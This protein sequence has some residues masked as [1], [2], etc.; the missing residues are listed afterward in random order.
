MVQLAQL[1][2]ETRRA[3]RRAELEQSGNR[4]SLEWAFVSSMAESDLV[5]VRPQSDEN[6]R[7][8]A[9]GGV[10]TR[11]RTDLPIE[12]WVVKHQAPGNNGLT[13][14]KCLVPD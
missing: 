11:S 4:R 7:L 13:L 8:L 2:E 3:K 14:L 12:E 9:Q 1:E 10:F 5:F 6:Q